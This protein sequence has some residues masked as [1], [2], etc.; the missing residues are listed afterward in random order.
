MEVADR[1]AVVTGATG[2]IGA[3]TARALHAAGARCV[4]AGRKADV[5]AALAA[6]LDAAA[7]AGDLTD[8][9]DVT[10]LL[11]TA[12]SAYGRI[13]ILVSNAGV[14]RA[15]P[16][17]TL[18]AD[19]VDGLLQINLRA[20]IELVRRALPGMVERRSGHIVLVSSIAGLV[21]VRDETVYAAAKAGL[22]GFADSLADE[23]HGTGVGVTVVAPGV[24]ETEFFARRGRP[25]DRARPRPMPPT[26][27]ADAI[28][29]AIRTDQFQVVVPRWLGVVARLR[30]LAPG[31]YRSLSARWG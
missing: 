29:R 22:I 23:L 25:Y 19:D 30:G 3:A 26:V 20:P 14:G 13:D 27:V 5:L 11:D 18:T 8:P 31:L 9:A 24:V 7:V 2:G 4:L 15:A 21:G 10:L 6:E 12:S 17:T 16:L 1:V 28:V